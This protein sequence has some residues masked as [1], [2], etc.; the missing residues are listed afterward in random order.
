MMTFQAGLRRKNAPSALI[1]YSG[2]LPGLDRLD[3]IETRTPVLIVHGTEDDVVPAYHLNGAETAL[4]AAG[5]SVDAHLLDGLDH[6]IDERG[7]ALGG[8]FLS[9]AFAHQ[10]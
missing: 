5:V 10:L 7:L 1:A 9:K 4:G 2:L 6:T 8:R 3:G